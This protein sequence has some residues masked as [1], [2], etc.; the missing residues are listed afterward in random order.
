MKRSMIRCSAAAGDEMQNDFGVGGRLV[1]RPFAN[2]ITPQRQAIRQIA[3]MGYGEAAGIELGEKRLHIAQDRLA[4][5]RIA[6]M[7]DRRAAR[8]MINRL[9]R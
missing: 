3:V 7:A 4:G 2:E 9:A 1:D 6:D 8:Q 5:G